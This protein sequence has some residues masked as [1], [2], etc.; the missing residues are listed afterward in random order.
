MLPFQALFAGYGANRAWTS[1]NWP[2]SWLI[3]PCIL[4]FGVWWVLNF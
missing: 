3:V 2:A 1:R 4:G